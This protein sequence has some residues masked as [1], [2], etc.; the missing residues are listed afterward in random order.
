[1]TNRIKTT[2]AQAAFKNIVREKAEGAAGNNTLVSKA[3]AKTLDPFT[4][5]AE[6]ALRAEG[7]KGARIHVDALVER[8][9]ADAM[10]TWEEFN[11]PNNGVDSVYLAKAEVKEIK[12]KDPAL[13]A[14]TDLAMLRAGKRGQDPV[15]VVKDFF[16]TFDFAHRRE[17]NGTLP[18][19]K[20][21]DARVGRPDRIGLPGNAHAAFDFFYRVE[22]RDIGGVSLHEGK[23]GNVEVLA[24]FVGTDGDDGYFE[25]MTKAGE[26]LTSGRLM[27]EEL[28]AFDSFPGRTRLSP[29]FTATLADYKVIEGYSEPADIELHGQVPRDWPADVVIDKALLHHTGAIHGLP[30][31]LVTDPSI[32]LTDEQR[33]VAIAALDFLWSHHLK[34]ASTDMNPVKLAPNWS[35]LKIGYYDHPIEGERFMVAD[36]R[37]IDDGSYTLYYRM[38]DEG[39]KLAIS[40]FN[41]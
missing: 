40:Q 25:V 14:L 8:A 22:A 24:I 20:R 12:Q 31:D 34:F 39:P 6:E 16:T 29:L 33:D 2:D 9:N 41:N 3:E 15:A 5:R 32:T 4:K 19:G 37:D 30:T 36:W 18:G 35:H 21:I 1:V 7:G 10:K 28:V 26:Y 17:T 13:G 27:G 11:P 38:T 23:I